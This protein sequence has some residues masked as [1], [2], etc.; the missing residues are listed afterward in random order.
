MMLLLKCYTQYISK[1][2]KVSSGHR[3]GI[4]QFSFQSQR[5]AMAK[6]I[7][8]I[9]QLHSFS[10]ASKVMLKILQAS[11]QKYVNQECPDYSTIACTSH[12]SKVMLKILQVRLQQY[13]NQEISDEQARF[14]KGRETRYQSASIHW[15]IGK[16]REFQKN[17]YFCFVDYAKAFDSVDY[18]EQ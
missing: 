18:N 10:R 17:I 11:L 16:A 5:R 4:G 9:V 6:N 1:F 12:A 2:G 15:I 13:M 7:Q 3:T 14:R 8:T